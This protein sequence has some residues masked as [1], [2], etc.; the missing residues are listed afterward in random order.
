MCFVCCAL[1]ARRAG[2]GLMQTYF[3]AGSRGHVCYRPAQ[4]AIDSIITN[5]TRHRAGA[6]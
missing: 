1:A 4:G 5:A 3:W 2:K 6:S